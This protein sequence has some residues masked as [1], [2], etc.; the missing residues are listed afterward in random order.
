MAVIDPWNQPVH[1]M[2]DTRT[3][4]IQGQMIVANL[5]LTEYATINDDPNAI[6]LDLAYQL[7]EQIVKHKLAEFTKQVNHSNGD[8]H[9]R[10]RTFVTR[11]SDVKIL[12]TLGPNA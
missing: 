5:V 4:P 3:Y 2:M 11:D 12:R 8:I 6:K 1:S 9:Y 7:A 10:A